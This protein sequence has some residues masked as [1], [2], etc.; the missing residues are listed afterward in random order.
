MKDAGDACKV[1]VF[2]NCN[3]P[4]VMGARNFERLQE[5]LDL[6]FG[7]YHVGRHI[8]FGL[9][10]YDNA[11]DYSFIKS[12]LLRY[13]QRQL[14]ISLTVP[15]IGCTASID[16]LENFKER[17]DFLFRFFREMDSIGVLPYYDCNKPPQCIWSEDEWVWL[18]WFENKY[19]GV[20]SNLTTPTAFCRPVVDILPDLR[21]VRCFGMSDF[22]KVSIEDFS[23]LADL[24]RYFRNR[25]DAEA[26][27]LCAPRLPH[28]LRP[29]N[30]LLCRRLSR[31]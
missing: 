1:R 2:V 17:K 7:P 12:L 22:E 8:K 16:P 11:F 19:S 28:L 9:N 23:C 24:Q 6:A 15:D 26:F 27:R 25:I 13:D 10:L 21:A 4:K 5:S 29:K 30:R 31:L 18:C 3:S 14:R 20:A